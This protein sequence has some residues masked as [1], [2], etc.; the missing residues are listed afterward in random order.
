MIRHMHLVMALP[1]DDGP[2]AFAVKK[3][4]WLPVE[5]KRCRAS[6]LRDALK[7]GPPVVLEEGRQ[8]NGSDI[9][10]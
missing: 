9:G 4:E 6:T 3:A 7:I 2:I 1:S 8:R 10:S 5:G